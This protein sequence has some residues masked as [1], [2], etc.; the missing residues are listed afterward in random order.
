MITKLVKKITPYFLIIIAVLG[1]TGW[2][3]S[4]RAKETK[5]EDLSKN[6]KSIFNEELQYKPVEKTFGHNSEI[7][8]LKKIEP[9]LLY[10]NYNRSKTQNGIPQPMQVPLLVN[11]SGTS[12]VM[13]AVVNIDYTTNPIHTTI[14]EVKN[15]SI[16]IA[17]LKSFL[18]KNLNEEW[19]RDIDFHSNQR[20]V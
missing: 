18:A 1:N 12:S 7:L 2:I 13:M 16:D 14:N 20:K 9:S 17:E 4:V 10:R 5:K 19:K 3:S 8:S 6:S 11:A 15:M